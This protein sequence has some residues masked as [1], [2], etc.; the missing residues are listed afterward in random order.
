MAHDDVVEDDVD[1]GY[2]M[3]VER[4]DEGIGRSIQ[5]A[6]G[7][8]E[9]N[10]I[11]DLNRLFLVA[12]ELVVL[13]G[14][15]FLWLIIIAA[16]HLDLKRRG[17]STLSSDVV[18]LLRL[19]IIFLSLILEVCG[20]VLLC[21]T[22]STLFLD[23]HLVYRHASVVIQRIDGATVL[24][25]FLRDVNLVAAI[26]T[27]LLLLLIMLTLL[28]GVV[29]LIQIC[30]ALHFGLSLHFNLL[31]RHGTK[32]LDLGETDRARLLPILVLI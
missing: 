20:D 14:L 19:E 26:K 8:H 13:L 3:A 27:F 30:A 21:I 11:A 18:L 12:S 10:D 7:D 4:C 17:A 28:L 9:L 15:N 22:L 6:L 31:R 23:R 32:L 25:I 1:V 2:F 24:G 5:I 29:N 16:F